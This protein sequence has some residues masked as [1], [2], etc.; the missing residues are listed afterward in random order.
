M[1]KPFI[2]WVGGKQKILNNFI[3]KIPN[4]INNYH[5]LFLGGG[6]FLFMI[7]HLK[8]TNKINITGNIYAYDINNNL[9]N[10]YNNIKN[11]KDELYTE[12]L[13]YYNKY[14]S[15]NTVDDKEKYYYSVRDIYN[16]NN[17][18]DEIEKSAIFIFLNKTCFRGLYREGPNGFNVPYGNYKKV[19]IISQEELNTIS[20]LIEN[21]NF[22]CL[23]FSESIKN[24]KS[25]DF[26]YLDPPYYPI[27]D[28]SFTDYNY[29]KFNKE[30][31]LELF[32][33]I[34]NFKNIKFILS[35]SNTDIVI[36][37]FKNYHID[38]INVKRLINSKN[39]SANEKE[40]IIYN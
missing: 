14:N 37:N 27:N 20:K 9:I 18:I 8:N 11:N 30:R 23:D 24:V 17:E 15:Y 22:I 19:I 26:V 10:L 39:P 28:K 4:N 7:L 25:G 36:N 12:L 33:Y 5:E 1:Q 34:N 40:V 35:N 2:K 29:K 3:E 31:Q 21:V 38:K 6:S 13:K 32:N 16:K